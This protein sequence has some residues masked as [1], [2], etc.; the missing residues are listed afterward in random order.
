M[1]F[2]TG[3]TG[4]VGTRL[5]FDLV[6]DGKQV[7]AI[8]RKT[9]SLAMLE[10]IFHVLSDRA[11]ELLKQIEW[12]DGDVQDYLSLEVAFQGIEQVYHCAAVVSFDPKDKAMMMRINLDG[13]ANVVN[14]ALDTGIKKL[15]F[16]SSVAALGRGEEN[17]MIDE[18]GDWSDSKENSAYAK[19][20]YTAEREVWRGVAEGL[21]A[22]IVNPS[23]I[24][25]PGDPH[26]SSAKLLATSMKGNPFYTEGVNAFVDVRDVSRTMIQLME[27]AIVNERFIINQGNYSYRHIFN[28]MAEGFGKEHPRVEVKPWMF[29]ILWRLDKFRNM[30][31]GSSPLITRETART[32][33]R[34]YLYSNEKIRKALDFSFIPIENSIKDNCNW[35]R[36]ISS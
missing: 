14:A 7:R 5:L 11:E 29:E 12:V 22:V 28:L 10:K 3:G 36:Q 16:V 23:I 31:S 9:S 19:S 27:S 2:V 18:N 15:C 34:R 20:K 6:A 35:F 4:L 24:L 8:K 26:K 1:I 30:V 13:T 25:G 32:S 33:S 21:K 17:I